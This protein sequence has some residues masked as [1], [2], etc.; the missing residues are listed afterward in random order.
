[1]YNTAVADGDRAMGCVAIL[2]KNTAIHSSLNINTTLQA[3]AVRV[4]LHKV[5]SI[6]SI[7]IPPGQRLFQRDLDHLI[8]QLPAPFLLRSF[9]AF[10]IF[11]NLVSQK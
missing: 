7:Y 9:G 2:V 5:I 1:M 11:N 6:C 4:T 10:P 8:A 3:V